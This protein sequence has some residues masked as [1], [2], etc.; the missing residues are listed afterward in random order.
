MPMGVLATESAVWWVVVQLITLSTLTTVELNKV[1]VVVIFQE[2][3][4]LP[5][6]APLSHPLR[7]DQYT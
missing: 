4:R 2:N 7:S 3:S 1:N 6:L 5:K